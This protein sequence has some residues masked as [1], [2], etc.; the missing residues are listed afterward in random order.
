MNLE[1]I[2]EKRG[3]HCAEELRLTRKLVLDAHP[4]IQESIK[5]GL[6][7][8]SIKRIMGYMDVQKEKPLIAFM[9]GTK[10]GEL[11]AELDFTGR[12]RVGHFFLTDLDDERYE[13]L[14]A[15]IDLAVEYDLENF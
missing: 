10:F 5:Y 7:F 13:I 3:Q 2:I 9:N 1:S 11:S 12:K 4:A 14:C 15:L 8:F 6:P